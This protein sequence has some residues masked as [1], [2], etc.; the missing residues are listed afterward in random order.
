MS[1]LTGLANICDEEATGDSVDTEYLYP[2]KEIV[3]FI[4]FE[5]KGMDRFIESI[6]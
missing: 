2:G 6:W 3:L 1:I 4:Q 5:L